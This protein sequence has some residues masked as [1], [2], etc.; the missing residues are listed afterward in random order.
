METAIIM[1]TA[2]AKEGH[3]FM[4]ESKA[5]V[6]VKTTVILVVLLVG[7]ET[8]AGMLRAVVEVKTMRRGISRRNKGHYLYD[9]QKIYLFT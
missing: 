2:K 5:M 9:A 6:V 3:N 8:V 7:V 1:D 4:V